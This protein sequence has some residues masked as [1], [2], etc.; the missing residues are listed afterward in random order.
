MAL[1]L[2][3]LRIPPAQFWTMTLPELDA[4]LRGALGLLPAEAVPGFDRTSLTAL[5]ARFPD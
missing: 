1:A 4:V 5:Q 3:R 2:G